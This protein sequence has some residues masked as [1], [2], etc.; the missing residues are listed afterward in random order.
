ML[1][2]PQGTCRCIVVA[3]HAR[4]WM[5]AVQRVYG[6]SS[7]SHVGALPRV[8]AGARSGAL[9][10]GATWRPLRSSATVAA[11]RL[12]RLVPGSRAVPALVPAWACRAAAVGSCSRDARAANSSASSIMASRLSVGAV[13]RKA[14]PTTTRLHCA[15]FRVPTTTTSRCGRNR[16]TL[17]CARRSVRGRTGIALRWSMHS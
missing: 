5:R 12:R 9:T 1:R 8:V 3:E 15:R 13:R 11:R 2:A 10:S 17:V 4:A 16:C 7:C 6:S 14:V